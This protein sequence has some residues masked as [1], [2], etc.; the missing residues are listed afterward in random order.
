MEKLP[1]LYQ[2]QLKTVQKTIR[3]TLMEFNDTRRTWMG[4]Q[5]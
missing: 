5:N 4:L 3:L 1:F 2:K